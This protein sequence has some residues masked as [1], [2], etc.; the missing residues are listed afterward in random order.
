[1]LSHGLSKQAHN[2][3][4]RWHDVAVGA[5]LYRPGGPSQFAQT[6]IDGALVQARIPTWT[7]ADWGNP[8]SPASCVG[9]MLAQ[10]PHQEDLWRLS[11]AYH[12]DED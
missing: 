12:A 3:V 6:F 9:P 4:Q 2:H 5:R 11:Q 10:G 7:T 1:M 8:L